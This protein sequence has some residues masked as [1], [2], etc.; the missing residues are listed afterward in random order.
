MG[1]TARRAA[2]LTQEELADQLGITQAALSR[3][4]NDL[5]NPD[6]ATVEWMSEILDVSPDFLTG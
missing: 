2:G 5:A 1:L 3:Y 4:E 6:D